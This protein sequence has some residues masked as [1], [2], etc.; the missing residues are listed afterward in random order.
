[1]QPEASRKINFN[2]VIDTCFDDG[3]SCIQ[4]HAATQDSAY[5]SGAGFL[6]D[7][8]RAWVK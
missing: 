3:F 4:Y 1:M 8:W 6:Q 2:E 7:K 5:K